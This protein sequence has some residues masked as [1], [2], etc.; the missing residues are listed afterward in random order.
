MLKRNEAA[1]T[2]ARVKENN[3]TNDLIEISFAL[4]RNAYLY[5]TGIR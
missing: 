2:K 1:S 5:H 4:N 3:F